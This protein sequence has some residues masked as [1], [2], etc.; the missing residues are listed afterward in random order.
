M[1]LKSSSFADLAANIHMAGSNMSEPPL[2]IGVIDLLYHANQLKVGTDSINKIALSKLLKQHL[3]EAARI[4]GNM[5]LR[6][7]SSENDAEQLQA[8]NLLGFLGEQ[9]YTLYRYPQV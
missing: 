2:A 1:D 3:P 5:L 6:N 7:L 9:G 4:G 8:M